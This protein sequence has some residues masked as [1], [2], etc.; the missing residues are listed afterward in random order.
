MAEAV[1]ELPD[2]KAVFAAELEAAADEILELAAAAD[3]VEA[4]DELVELAELP[5]DVALLLAEEAEPSH[6]P[7]QDAPAMAKFVEKL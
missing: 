7:T 6:I 3:E 4:L 1:R 2:E 5:V